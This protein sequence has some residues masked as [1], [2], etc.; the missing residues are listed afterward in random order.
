MPSIYE[1]LVSLACRLQ[2]TDRIES[3]SAPPSSPPNGVSVRMRPKRQRTR[4]RRP[5][6]V[7]LEF[8]IAAPV[9][10]IA[11]IAIFEFAFLAITLQFGHGALIE[12][13]RRGAELYPPTYSFDSPGANN[14]ISDAVVEAVNLYLAIH[15]LEIF[16]PTQD[17]VDDLARPNAQIMI[18]RN[19]MLA[20]RGA[21]VN[22][23]MG[24]VCTPSGDPPD[25]DE[26]RVT[27]CFPLVDSANPTGYG[28]PVPDW[29]SLYGVSLTNS[30]FEVSARMPLE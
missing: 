4:N 18:E 21:G 2:A 27:L 11:I 14:D 29:L 20:T 23:P 7:T 19:G 1:F 5:G 24:F 26:I 16:D 10:F 28:R 30:V 13:T 6:V 12:G 9:V 3:V 15:N 25:G 8:I 22:F 17:F